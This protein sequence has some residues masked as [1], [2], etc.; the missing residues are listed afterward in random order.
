MPS[1]A[2]RVTVTVLRRPRPRR[3]PVRVEYSGLTADQE[4]RLFRAMDLAAARR[5][6]DVAGL[7]DIIFAALRGEADVVEVTGSVDFT[8]G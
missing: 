4:G 8:G 3:C 6:L 7:C 1:D 5:R 2:L